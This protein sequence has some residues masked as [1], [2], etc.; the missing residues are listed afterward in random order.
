MDATIILQDGMRFVATA[1]SGHEVIMDSAVSGGGTDMGSR[2]MELLAMGLG[3]CTAMD[4][5][6]I[7]RKKRQ[8]VTALEVKV[9]GERVDE[10]PKVITS[11]IIEYAVSGR[12]ID[13]AAVERAIALSAERYCPAQAMLGRAATMELIYKIIEVD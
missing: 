13:P 12:E 3:G 7:L 9:H 11:F 8:D 10:H 5:I 2:P 1:D 4:V 6:S